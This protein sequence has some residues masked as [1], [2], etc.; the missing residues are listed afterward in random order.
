MSVGK[1]TSYTNKS[2]LSV[3]SFDELLQEYISVSK[4]LHGEDFTVTSDEFKKLLS[5]SKELVVFVLIA[6]LLVATA[7]ASLLW[8]PP[9][10]QVYINNVVTH[11]EYGGQGLG[12]IAMSALEDCIR[13]EW[14][15]NEKKTIHLILSN[16]PT[17]RNGGFYEKLGWTSRGP[18]S[19]NPTVVWVK[20]V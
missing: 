13:S 2:V 17:K 9:K 19:T 15:E 4:R 5:D 20:T 14:G 8:T 6:N 11:L 12:R 18:D 7:Q 16:S 1:P 10:L 3:K